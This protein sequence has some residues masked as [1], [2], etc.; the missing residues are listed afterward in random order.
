[1][2]ES[3]GS[4]AVLVCG[5][6]QMADDA[7]KAAVEAVADGHAGLGYFEEYFGW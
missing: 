2:R 3:A 1:M 4:T 7:R 5:P 6:A